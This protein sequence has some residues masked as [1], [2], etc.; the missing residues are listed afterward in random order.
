MKTE[1]TK[2]YV[3]CMEKVK[4]QI[5]WVR[6]LNSAKPPLGGDAQLTAEL[7]FV[8]FRKI[9]ELIAF[10][11]LTSNKDAYARAYKNFDEHWKAE[12][13]LKCVG[14]LNP[15]FY[16]TP[17]EPPRREPGD[18][19]Y[20]KPR[21]NNYLTSMTSRGSTTLLLKSC[22]CR[23]HSQRKTRSRGLITPSTNTRCEF[24]S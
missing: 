2:V 15:H 10:A 14:K 21:V 13:I 12:Q 1:D 18:I 8:Q 17:L 9:L 22:T 5:T 11:S 23:T 20:N 7:S 4:Q 3:K 16:P 19:M 24:T 6:W